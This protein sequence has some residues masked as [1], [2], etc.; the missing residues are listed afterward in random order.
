MFEHLEQADALAGADV[1]D[2]TLQF[3]AAG[4]GEQV[5]VHHVVDVGEVAGLLSIA[6]DRRLRAAGEGLGE[7]G[8]RRRIGRVG[9]LPRAEDVE[10]AK[11]HR[12]ER[13]AVRERG[14]E[15]FAGDFAGGIRRAAI[16]WVVFLAGQFRRPPIGRGGG[17]ENHPLHSASGFLRRF[18]HAFG[19][20]DVHLGAPGGAFH[21]FG[22][23]DHR[24][25][26]KDIDAAACGFAQGLF[27]ENRLLDESRFVGHIRAETAGKVIDH[28]NFRAQ[29]D[30]PPRQMRTDEARAAGDKDG[31]ADEMARIIGWHRIYD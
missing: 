13:I 6:E 24:R 31:M 30:Q 27:I 8:D 14:A 3:A 25:L 5:R 15:R 20:E 19:A 18:Q 9:I 16:D 21:A 29:F 1:D 22:H 12:R 2:F 23:A 4:G 7:R 26:M 11:T 28:P 10:V 17:G